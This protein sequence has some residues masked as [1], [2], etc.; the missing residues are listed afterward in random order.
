MFGFVL[1][2]NVRFNERDNEILRKTTVELIDA[3]HRAGGTFY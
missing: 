2:L 3:A 1:Y